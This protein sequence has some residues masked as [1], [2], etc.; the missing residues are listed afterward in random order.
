MIPEQ[1]SGGL[2]RLAGRVLSPM[3]INQLSIFTICALFV[4]V[5]AGADEFVNPKANIP[6][7]AK[8]DR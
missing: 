6:P 8:P 7:L 2:G 1:H 4:C 3:R 5:V